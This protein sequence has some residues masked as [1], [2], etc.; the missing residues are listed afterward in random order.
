MKISVIVGFRNREISR[1]V[2]ALDALANQ[3][4]T[5]FELVF[6]DYGSDEAIA[7]QAETMV[8]KY[9]FAQYY[10]SDTRGWFWNRA[11]ALNT[12]V[13]M[14]SGELILFFDIDLILE[15]DFLQ[16]IVMLDYESKFYTFSCFYLPAHFDLQKKNIEQEGLQYEQNYVGLCAVKRASVNDINGF[17][18]YYMVWGVEDDDFYKRLANFGIKRIQMQAV[19]FRVF[20]QWHPTEA[21]AKP[22]LWYLTMVNYFYSGAGQQQNSLSWGDRIEDI[23]RP[24]FNLIKSNK[25]DLDISL[26]DK[27]GFLFY[28]DF[29]NKFYDSSSKSGCLVYRESEGVTEKKSINLFFSKKKVIENLYQLKEVIQFIQYF[30]GMNRNNILDYFLQ[31]EKS[32]LKLYYIKK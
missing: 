15:K 25:I 18:E 24:L 9:S 5:D 30:I 8:A 27:C 7:K 1:L 2:Y 23:Q 10:Y 17:D 19:D 20:H 12:G 21:P 13:K 4:L 11:H 16:K 22:T 26:E 29:I 28:N 31:I 32:E 14:S 6:I 3:S